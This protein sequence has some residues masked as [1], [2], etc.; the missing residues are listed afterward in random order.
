MNSVRLDSLSTR[1]F[2][3]LLT[4]LCSEQAQ[5]QAS[6]YAAQIQLSGLSKQVEAMQKPWSIY[7]AQPSITI[8]T[9]P[10]KIDEIQMDVDLVAPPQPAPISKQLS[11]TVSSAKQAVNSLF[12][13]EPMPQPVAG[14]SSFND[15]DVFAHLPPPSPAPS[16]ID[17]PKARSP[18]KPVA[19]PVR[20]SP[21]K[22]KPTS[23]L[24]IGAKIG[25]KR[26]A[27]DA[28]SPDATKTKKAK[29]ELPK[30]DSVSES[31]RGFGAGVEAVSSPKGRLRSRAAGK[32]PNTAVTMKDKGKGRA[33]VKSSN[34]ARTTKK[35][36]K[37]AKA[38]AKGTEARHSPK[39]P[40]PLPLVNGTAAPSLPTFVLPPPSPASRLPSMHI[41]SEAGPSTI[42]SNSKND[43]NPFIS[44]DQPQ[45]SSLVPTTQASAAS[46]D[47]SHAPRATSY[48]ASSPALDGIGPI[49]TCCPPN[50]FTPHIC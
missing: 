50:P 19:A 30:K 7:G 8:P 42:P 1:Q 2:D 5:T 17:E 27:S 14:P 11:N 23:P 29:T 16:Y 20:R 44:S 35:P 26:K 31:V 32:E 46:S 4:F 6:T 39:P 15:D 33:T 45:T 48:P 25:L 21:R 3:I 13:P 10:A 18:V 49:C 28:A 9:L 37:A 41:P 40:A 22:P 38:P 47:S 43:S 36:A 34:T 24:R 12:R